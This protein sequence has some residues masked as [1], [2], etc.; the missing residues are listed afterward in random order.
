[1][2]SGGTEF[3]RN[4]ILTSINRTPFW[5]SMATGNPYSKLNDVKVPEREE[6]REFQLESLKT[7]EKTVLDNKV[8]EINNTLLG[9]NYDALLSVFE[10]EEN[11][12][13][14]EALTNIIK[15]TNG[16]YHIYEN[17]QAESAW[18]GLQTKLTKLKIA[19]ETAKVQLQLNDNVILDS[20][21]N[22][23][24]EAL[25]DCGVRDASSAAALSKTIN[26][27]KG[28]LVEDIGVAWLN[29]LKIP[30]MQSIR[31]GNVSLNTNREDRH[32]GQ[33]VQDLITFSMSNPDI[34]KDTIIEY[35]PIGSSTFEKRTLKQ[36]IYDMEQLPTDSKDKKIIINDAGYDALLGLNGIAVQAKSG[37]KQKLWNQSKYNRFAIN[38]LTDQDKL[39]LS[40]KET[41]SLLNSLDI[42]EDISVRDNSKD[43]DALMN[44][45]IGTIMGRILSLSEKEGNQYVLTPQ[46]FT[47]F[48]KRLESLMKENDYI[49][50]TKESISVHGGDALS[51][52]YDADLK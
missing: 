19:L 39:V 18:K 1:M 36:F 25:K 29:A 32:G 43:Y 6:I 22:Q 12:V 14:S 30:D 48:S 7:Y 42:E 33:L 4:N 16:L 13:L 8:A 44:Y 24:G 50:A 23:V 34:L 28:S 3:A 38:D 9:T 47:T 31:G 35:K 51:R 17:I 27:F 20:Y 49:V 15:A 41:F 37:L 45:G 21:I 10:S 26:Q 52:P 46:G 11:Q 2:F 5:D 40:V